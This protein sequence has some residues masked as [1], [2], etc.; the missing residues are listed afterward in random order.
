LALK[1]EFPHNLYRVVILTSF[2]PKLRTLKLDR[3]KSFDSILV[4]PSAW[5]L[6]HQRLRMRDDLD[7]SRRHSDGASSNA[8]VGCAIQELA[9][10][11]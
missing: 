2:I 11:G 8:A 6:A 9:I 7:S 10:A 4:N 3:R 1:P 5:I